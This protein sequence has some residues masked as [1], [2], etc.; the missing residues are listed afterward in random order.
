MEKQQKQFGYSNTPE[1]CAIRS[2][3]PFHNLVNHMGITALMLF[4]PMNNLRIW[5]A[6][7]IPWHCLTLGG[8]N[9][10]NSYTLFLSL[11]EMLL[12]K[13]WKSPYLYSNPWTELVNPQNQLSFVEYLCL[14]LT[15]SWLL[16]VVQQTTRRG[17]VNLDVGRYLI[18]ADSIRINVHI[19]PKCLGLQSSHRD[20]LRSIHVCSVHIKIDCLRALL[21]PLAII[22]NL[23]TQISEILR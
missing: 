16:D 23:H 3:C 14:T 9:C 1:W 6:K 22:E 13:V 8:D 17:L 4:S 5:L 2:V 7:N 18:P 20:C 21:T 12:C 10:G 19:I 15:A 11:Y